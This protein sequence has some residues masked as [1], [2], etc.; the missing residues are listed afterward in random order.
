MFELTTITIRAALSVAMHRGWTLYHGADLRYAQSLFVQWCQVTCR[1]LRLDVRVVG[2]LPV[3]PC[4]ILSNHRSYLDVAVLGGYVEAAFLARADISAWPL[5]GYA[6]RSLGCVFVER[7]ETRGRSRAARLLLRSGR[8]R[9]MV[10]FPE[11]TTRGEVD[12]G[13][14]PDGLSRLMFRLG[15]PIVPVTLRYS[16]R[17]VYWVEELPMRAHLHDRVLRG[18]PVRCEVEIGDV[19]QPHDFPDPASLG[20][21]IHS[22][23]SGPIRMRGEL[24]D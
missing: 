14:V 19:V 13:V 15:V 21:A 10:I 24:C 11:G 1:T 5:V 7:D 18:G 4:L 8:E 20:A 17:D 12:P 22:A 16:R 23:L 3:G 2:R 9:R 6:A